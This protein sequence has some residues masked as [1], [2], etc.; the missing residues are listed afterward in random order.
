MGFLHREARLTLFDRLVPT[1][2]PS[3]ASLGMASRE[4]TFGAVPGN[5]RGISFPLYARG[6]LE[7]PQ[8]VPRLVAVEKGCAALL[9]P[10]AAIE[11]R[12]K[13]V[14]QLHLLLSFQ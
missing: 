5:S 13:T 14:L 10:A 8:E 11:P 4:E 2:P 6:H 1:V 7:I 3:C 9:W 12:L